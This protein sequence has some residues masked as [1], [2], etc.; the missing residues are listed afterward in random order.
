M[1]RYKSWA[2]LNRQLS[3]CLCDAFKP[4]ITYFLTGYSAV[5]NAHG[6]AAIRLDGKEL[7]RFS[8]HEMYRQEKQLSQLSAFCDMPFEA[9]QNLL[10]PQWNADCAYSEMDFLDAALRFRNLPIRDALESENGII[11]ILGILDRRVGKRTLRQIAE[12]RDYEGLP[13]WVS[14]FYRLRLSECRLLQEK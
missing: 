14:Q 10:K 3:E 12:R 11:R 8:W 7:V 6:R 13:H 5:H 2:G 4:R 9:A 1:D